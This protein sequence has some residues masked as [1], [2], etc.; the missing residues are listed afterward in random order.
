M[1]RE[2]IADLFEVVDGTPNLVESLATG[3][4]SFDA[5]E[6]EELAKFWVLDVKRVGCNSFARGVWR[7]YALDNMETVGWITLRFADD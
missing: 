1:R 4:Y 5:I 7:L 3:E 6:E 2:I